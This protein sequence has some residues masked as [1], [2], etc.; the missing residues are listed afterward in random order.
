[1]IFALCTGGGHLNAVDALAADEA[2]CEGAGLQSTVPDSRRFGKYLARFTA[3][4]LDGLQACV[5]AVS[6][7]V[8]PVFIDSTGIE[9]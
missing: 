8:V 1:M 3:K 6:A 4:D 5:R 7:Q 2:A 9:V